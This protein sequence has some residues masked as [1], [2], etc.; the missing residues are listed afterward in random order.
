VTV[1][2]LCVYFLVFALVNSCVFGGMG[3]CL[4][5]SLSLYQ[6]TCFMALIKF[7]SHSPWNRALKLKP[8]NQQ[9]M[10]HCSLSG[11]WHCCPGTHPTSGLAFRVKRNTKPDGSTPFRTKEMSQMQQCTEVP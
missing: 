7:P 3:L 5:L 11:E 8:A 6:Q 10:C 1:K 9:S 2:Q 4:L